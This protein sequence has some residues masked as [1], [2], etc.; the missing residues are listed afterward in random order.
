MSNILDS[1][2][3]MKMLIQADVV[4]LDQLLCRNWGVKKKNN[5]MMSKIKKKNQHD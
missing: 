4:Y 5:K 2:T 3:V 1:I